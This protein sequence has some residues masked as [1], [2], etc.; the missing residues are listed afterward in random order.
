MWMLC[1]AL[2]SY[3]GNNVSKYEE[4]TGIAYPL[5]MWGFISKLYEVTGTSPVQI[6]FKTK[7]ALEIDEDQLETNIR[8]SSTY[9]A[10]FKST[11]S[12]Q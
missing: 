4:N 1:R 5:Q 11:L 8:K 6:R 2:T 9:R 10:T 7:G 3:L 12:S